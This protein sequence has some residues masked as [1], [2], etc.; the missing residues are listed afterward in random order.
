M[1]KQLSSI[2]TILAIALGTCLAGPDTGD[3]AVVADAAVEEGSLLEISLNGAWDSRYVSEGRDNLDGNSL[4]STTLEVGCAGFTFSTWYAN[5]PEVAFSELDLGIE[6]GF[7]IGAWAA[8]FGFVHLRYPHDDATENELGAGLAYNG[9]PWGFV[10]AVAW[11]YLAETDGSYFETSLF[12]PI[13]VTDTIALEPGVIVGFNAGYMG[14]GHD[15]A[16]HVALVLPVT[17]ALTENVELSAYVSYQWAIDSDPV[18][19]PDDE[20]LRDF[21]WGGVAVGISF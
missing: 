15:G 16:D 1:K 21:F 11:T 9:L 18:N 14:D 5:S 13:E 17:F 3:K 7:E 20:L 12:R 6:Y 4:L 10:P 19:C 2:L 8:Y